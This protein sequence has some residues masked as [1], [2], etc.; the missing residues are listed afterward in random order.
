M[1]MFKLICLLLVVTRPAWAGPSA[2]PDGGQARVTRVIDGD[3]I[4]L[5]DGRQV[6][7]VGIQA[8]KLPLGRPDFKPWPLGKEAKARL[9]TLIKGQD[10]QL[11]LGTNP[12]D[13]HGR[14]LAHV[15]RVSDGLWLQGALLAAGLARV[16]TFPDNRILASE[17]LA[18]ERQ[19]RT[20]AI[21]LWALPYYAVRGADNVHHDIGSFQVVEDRVVDVAKVKKRIYLNFGADWR[22]DFTVK[23][24]ARYETLFQAAGVDLL[25]LKGRRV[26]V[27]G[28]VK[29]QNGP[30]IELDHP[31]RL[32]FIRE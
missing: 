18:L 4:V 15:V 22:S 26:R 28:W 30:M 13:R 10:V 20:D 7:L 32:E 3:T 29:D 8:P 5:E 1:Y 2:L 12:E 9:Q 21:G 19:A 6:R 23:I 16:Y 17:M 24:K 14:V 11:R 27:R 31:E 25:A